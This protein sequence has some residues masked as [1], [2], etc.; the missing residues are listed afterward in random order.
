M[1]K[2]LFNIGFTL[3]TPP[4]NLHGQK[5]VDY[6]ARRK[7][8][9]LTSEYNYFTYA[10]NEKK[11]VKN[12]DAEDYFTRSGMNAGLFDMDGALDNAKI[13]E[14]KK[15]LVDTKSIIWHGFISF[16]EETSVGFNTQ[17]N[18][19]KFL[20]QTFNA[21]L[22]RTHLKRDNI[23]LYA[24]LHD[25][26]DH[27]HIHFSFF[28]NEPRRR[29]KNGELCY[30]LKGK[31][32]SKAIDNYLVSANMH[33]DEHG[34]EYYTARDAAMT[35]LKTARK[36]VA[37]G[38]NRNQTLNFELNRLIAALPKEGRLQY[39]AQN[40]AALRPQIDRVAEFLI[41]SDPKASRAHS[42]ML[43]QLATVEK[44]VENLVKDN[45][46]AYVADERMSK[47]Q[48]K[49]IMQDKPGIDVKFVDLKNIDYFARLKEDYQARVGNVVLGL[50]KD[51]KTGDLRDTKRRPGK[52]N[53]KSLKIV[54]KR[55]RL[56]RVDVVGRV[57]ALLMAISIGEQANFL[58]SVH[59]IEQE[60][61]Y[62]RRAD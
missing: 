10:L 1:P 18:A 40:M 45:K 9:N 19:I 25:D 57:T 42:E 14:L 17:E 30:T 35:S 44:N 2:A 38:V 28:E 54:S 5:R 8:Y 27:R 51:I 59:Q 34:A 26:T 29:N 20:N 46:L 32:D 52:V 13:V 56:H 31:V 22:D 12:K 61:E 60:Q 50:C 47:E 16:D 55:K 24:S 7:F 4:S 33:L 39:R 23:C 15:K 48:I 62:E 6:M 49:D 36:E 53:D 21:F 58:K 11:V 3:P 37:S 41:A 43:K